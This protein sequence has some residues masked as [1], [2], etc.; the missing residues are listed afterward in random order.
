[1]E[2]VPCG[3]FVASRDA[4]VDRDDPHDVREG[5]ESRLFSDP[6]GRSSYR[7]AISRLAPMYR[8]AQYEFERLEIITPWL[9]A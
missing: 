3:G 7:V 4:V 9:D 2:S 1:M 5:D 6:F 8:A